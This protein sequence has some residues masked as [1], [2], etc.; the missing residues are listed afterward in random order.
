[1]IKSTDTNKCNVA[2]DLDI[3]SI[4]HLTRINS[5]FICFSERLHGRLSG[6]PQDVSS[7]HRLQQD[8]QD[9]N[10]YNAAISACNKG[11]R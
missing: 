6:W 9:I 2:M 5:L 3:Q 7:W 1:M 8:I 11:P 10:A 4:S